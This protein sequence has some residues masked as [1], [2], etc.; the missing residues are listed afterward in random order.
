MT[1]TTAFLCS[2]LCGWL[3]IVSASKDPNNPPVARTGAPGETTCG[4]SGCHTGGSFVGEVT[5]SGLPDTILLNTEYTITLKHKSNAVR[6]GFQ[7]T[8]LD[9]SNTKYGTL[10]AST[11]S[12]LGSQASTG[13][14]YVR[15][16]TPKTLSTADSSATWSF[17]WKS[18]TTAPAANTAKFYF[19][20]LAANGN[21][22]K[23]GDNVLLGTKQFYYAAPVSAVGEASAEQ[24]VKLYPSVATE[25]LHIDLANGAQGKA[26]LYTLGG[27]QVQ[28][29]A[30]NGSSTLAVQHLAPG[31]YLAKIEM[32]G[33]IV[34]KRWVKQ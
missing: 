5:V 18:P 31:I 3:F 11:G 8:C 17:V 25:V 12:S 23:T 4:A 29:A 9:N 30:I 13:R 16:A 7:L 26:T 1:K 27:A 15:Q 24:A 19:S 14:Q 32:N 28:Q 2:L 10:T 22:G 33:Q 20:S 34:T 6:A 21:N